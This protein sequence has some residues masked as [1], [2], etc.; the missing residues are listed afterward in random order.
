MVYQDLPHDP[1]G[2]REKM[3]AILPLRRILS[4][5]PQIGLVH[6]GRT[7]QRVV[8][9]FLPKMVTR[10]NSQFVVDQRHELIQR[11]AVSSAPTK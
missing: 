10:Q 4:G 11:F 1:R 5:K 2:D 6:Q 7:L 9:S 8:A 3:R